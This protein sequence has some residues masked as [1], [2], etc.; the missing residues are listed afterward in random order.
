MNQQV[1]QPGQRRALVIGASMAGLFATALLRKQGWIVDLFE[2]SD[3]ELFGRG[4]GIVTHSELLAALVESGADIERLGVAINDRIALDQRDNVIERLA[5]PQIVTSWDRLHQLMRD[6]IPSEHHHLGCN[7]QSIEQTEKGVTARFSN[8]RVE[9]ADLLIAA[10][11]YRSMVRGM[12]MPSVQPAYAGYVIWRGVAD[13]A[14]MPLSAKQTIFDKFAFFLPPKNKIIGYPIPGTDH[15]LEA[16]RRR[17][18]WVWYRP[19]DPRTLEDML[20]DEQGNH[21]PVSI[22]PPLVRQAL[23]DELKQAAATTLPPSFSDTLSVIP[24]PFFTPIYDLYCPKMVFGRVALIGDAA[25]VGRP[26]IGMGVAKAAADAQVLARLAGDPSTTVD[27]ALAAFEKERLVDGRRAF[28]RGRTLGE[29]LLLDEE[30]G[31]V[32]H[33]DHWREFHSVAGILKNTASSDFLKSL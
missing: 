18:N 8:G 28:E 5:Y 23:I 26:H 24:R 2:R 16:G 15:A 30:A 10:D 20:V 9:Q 17:F 25:S 32:N 31:V 3:V 11:G 4:A 27:E 6:T 21:H 7:L 22:P 12:Y 1:T 29:Y 33:D 13:E 19:V 14:D